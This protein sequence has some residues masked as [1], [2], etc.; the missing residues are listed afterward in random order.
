MNSDHDVF[1]NRNADKKC[2]IILKNGSRD[3][4]PE[5]WITQTFG[6]Q[7]GITNDTSISLNS[8]SMSAFDW[9]WQCS[10][11][12]RNSDIALNNDDILN[13]LETVA[14]YK[15]ANACSI[16]LLL[17]EQ[18][19]DIDSLKSWVDLIDALYDVFE[20]IKP[21]DMVVNS[22]KRLFVIDAHTLTSF[23]NE[24]GSEKL[25]NLVK[26]DQTFR[27]LFTKIASG[28]YKW[29]AGVILDVIIQC[30][31]LKDVDCYEMIFNEMD[32]LIRV[33]K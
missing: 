8:I 9:L 14:R 10:L 20:S 29:I 19:I 5:S 17:F 25:S 15:L 16:C 31:P 1:D 27:Q 3:N 26:H 7:I 6:V 21:N 2:T 4:I 12:Y 11:A 33:K 23:A 32:E 24:L 30:I 18:E 13:I 28:K 22:M